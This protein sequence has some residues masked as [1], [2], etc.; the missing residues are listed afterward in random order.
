MPEEFVPLVRGEIPPLEHVLFGK[1]GEMLKANVS[2]AEVFAKRL[3]LNPRQQELWDICDFAEIPDASDGTMRSLHMQCYGP[4][5]SSKSY[6]VYA[7]VLRQLLNFPGAKCLVIRTKLGEVKKSAWYDMKKMLSTYNIPFQKNETELTLHLPNGSMVQCSSDLALMPAGSDNAESLKSTAWSFVIFEEAD[8]LRESLA[9]SMA[10]RMR[11]NVGRFRKILFYICNPPDEFHWLYKWWFQGDNDPTDS[12][13]RY[14][15]LKFESRDNVQHVGEAY[16]DD[17]KED[18]SKNRFLAKRL[19]EGKY[20]IKPTGIPYFMDTF[21]EETHVTDLR[22]KN[23]EGQLVFKFNRLYPLQRGWDPG[24]RGMGCVVMQE[25]PELRQLR[26]FVARLVQ[27]THLETFLD[28]ILPEMNHFFP[29]ALWEDYVD[30]AAVQQTA[31]SKKSSLQ[32]MRDY[33]LHPRHRPMSVDS[34]LNVINRL[35]RL[36]SAGRP[37]VVLDQWGC[38]ILIQAFV[39]GYCCDT[40]GAKDTPK[41]DGIYEHIMDAFRYPVAHIFRMQEGGDLEPRIQTAGGREFQSQATPIA[42]YGQNI[43]TSPASLSSLGG[44]GGTSYRNPYRRSSYR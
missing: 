31:N 27:N 8:G 14:R 11:Q 4:T 21:F 13:C 28:D 12:T 22:V 6:G 33:G 32:I 35:L 41:K 24:F 36:S 19:G 9:I 5:G 42:G 44:G 38:N 37:R 2:Y 43:W 34:G 20:G 29:G 15:A 26:V 39:G 23:K 7:Y 3:K 18:F 40:A 25:D 10:G 16:L 30:T 17:I 1:L